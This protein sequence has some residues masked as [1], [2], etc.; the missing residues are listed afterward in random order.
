ME[1][2]EANVKERAKSDAAALQ[3]VSCGYYRGSLGHS[4]SPA[5]A[6][7]ACFHVY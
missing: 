3:A 1:R 5:G 7:L 4:L 2:L 6:T